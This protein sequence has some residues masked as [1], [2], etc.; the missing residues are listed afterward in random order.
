MVFPRGNNGYIN[1]KK[2]DFNLYKSEII[3]L[4]N[5]EIVSR[6]YYQSGRIENTLASDPYIKASEK[7]FSNGDYNKILKG[8]SN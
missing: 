7:I 4:L 8:T 1:S 2:E 3:E 6:Y 5:S